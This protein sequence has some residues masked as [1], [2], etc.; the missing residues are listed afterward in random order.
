MWG[1]TGIDYSGRSM[2]NKV[3]G[4]CNWYDHRIYILHTCIYPSCCKHLCNI[5]IYIIY[6]YV[7]IYI[8][9]YIY[10]YMYILKSLIHLTLM[11]LQ[12]VGELVDLFDDRSILA[13]N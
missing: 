3:H 8:Y 13:I 5:Y 9:I 6:M 2:W 11:Q 7:Y 10:I 4:S 1:W 12:T